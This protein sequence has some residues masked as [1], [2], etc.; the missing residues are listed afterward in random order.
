MIA[1]RE[2]TERD[3]YDGILLDAGGFVTETTSANLFWVNNETVF[4]PPLAVGLLGGITRQI[5][6]E[7]LKEKKVGFREQPIQPDE[8]K[9]AGEIFITGATLEVMPVQRIDEKQIG[10]GKPGPM[11]QKIRS[12][13]KNRLRHEIESISA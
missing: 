6:I 11:T 4:T 9:G 12:W 13:Y 10:H 7:I 2:F 8:L 1:R 3:S 5:V